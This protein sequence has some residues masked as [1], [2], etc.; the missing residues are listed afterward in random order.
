MKDDQ[1][2]RDFWG[3]C[4]NTYGEETKQ[5]VY[6]T[7]MG[8][9]HVF[10]KDRKSPF[11]FNIKGRSVIDIGGGPTSLLLKCLNRGACSVVDPLPFPPWVHWRYEAAGINVLPMRG[12]DITHLGRYDE[13][14]IYNCLQH[15]DNPKLVLMN[16]MQRAPTIRL[17]EWIDI[18]PHPG[19]PHMLTRGFL[20]ATLGVTGNVEQ[21]NEAGCVGRAFFGHWSR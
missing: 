11:N 1:F 2:E 21:L 3:D 6:A 19:H 17:F 9:K 5:L 13:V 8:L 15:T 4:T 7:R 10:D 16:A 20:E 18:P 14:W 12:E